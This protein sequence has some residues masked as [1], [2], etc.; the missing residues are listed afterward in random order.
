[1]FRHRGFVDKEAP[2]AH[3]QEEAQEDA[4][5]HPMAASGR[6]LTPLAADARIF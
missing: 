5:G 4:E 6:S 1:V 3:A 2:E